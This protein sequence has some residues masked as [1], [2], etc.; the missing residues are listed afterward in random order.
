M[1]S[2][3]DATGQLGT[4]FMEKTGALIYFERCKMSP[5]STNCPECIAFHPYSIP[6]SQCWLRVKRDIAHSPVNRRRGAQ[7]AALSRP[8]PETIA[9]HSKTF[10]VKATKNITIT[11]RCRQIVFGLLESEKQQI[12]RTLV[13]VEP[14]QTQ[15][16]GDF[17][18]LR[19]QDSSRAHTN[20]HVTSPDGQ[21]LTRA[22]CR[23]AILMLANFIDELVTVPNATILGVAENPPE[24]PVDKINVKS[25][26]DINP[27]TKPRRKR[28]N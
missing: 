27:P 12:L 16:E 17:S 26:K 24:P 4:D 8:H 28:K 19:F 13:C 20:L 3:T 21:T 6:H 23:S 7:R 22:P 5:T 14:A 18:A 9:L 10:L 2:S 1:S 11:P 25:K 15:I